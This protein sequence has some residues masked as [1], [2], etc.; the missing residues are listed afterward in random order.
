[1]ATNIDSFPITAAMLT[2]A[3]VK[4]TVSFYTAAGAANATDDYL[5]KTLAQKAGCPGSVNSAEQSPLDPVYVFAI[6]AEGPAVVT[7]PT[8]SVTNV[9][10]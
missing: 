2:Y 1:M 4:P 9:E 10:S 5:P 8:L 6:T 3:Y 7:V